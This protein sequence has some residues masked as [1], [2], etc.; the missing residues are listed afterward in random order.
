[1]AIRLLRGESESSLE[2]SK[3]L[4][5]PTLD[6][7]APEGCLED[8]NYDPEPDPNPQQNSVQCLD[9]ASK[10]KAQSDISAQSLIM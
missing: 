2:M 6:L 8:P 4:W 9:I 1:M 7:I 10:T 5:S 3:E